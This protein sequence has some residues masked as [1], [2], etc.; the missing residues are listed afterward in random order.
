MEVDYV[1]VEHADAARRCLP[2]T[3]LTPNSSPTL[4]SAIALPRTE[5]RPEF[6]NNLTRLPAEDAAVVR[7]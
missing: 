7:H 1:G 6:S 4:G 3:G 2:F 5:R